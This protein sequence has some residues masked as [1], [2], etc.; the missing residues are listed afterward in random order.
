M[1]WVYWVFFGVGICV[2][3]VIIRFVIV[4]CVFVRVK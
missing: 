4:S 2:I 1:S 3:I